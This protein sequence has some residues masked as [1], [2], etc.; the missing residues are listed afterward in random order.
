[1]K[2]IRKDF[3][4]EGEANLQDDDPVGP[5]DT[6]RENIE[7]FADN[8]ILQQSLREMID[9]IRVLEDVLQDPDIS[10]LEVAQTK[11]ELNMLQQ[12]WC[13]LADSLYEKG[14]SA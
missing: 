1:M 2:N 3:S 5:L 11:E 6:V 9:W 7:I 14:I 12:A 8:L 4:V 10:E 13:V